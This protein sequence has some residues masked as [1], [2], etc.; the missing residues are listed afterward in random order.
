MGMKGDPMKIIAII[1]CCVSSSWALV[2]REGY[3]PKDGVC[4]EEAPP[5]KPSDEL[6]PRTGIPPW[7]AANIHNVDLKP[8]NQNDP[9]W[10]PGMKEDDTLAKIDVSTGKRP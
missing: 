3:V 7:Q 2:C 4:M 8:E 6:P 10:K 5:V 1:L 9:N